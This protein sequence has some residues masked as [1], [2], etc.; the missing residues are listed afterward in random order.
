MRSR[1]L[2]PTY[3]I[4]VGVLHT[5]KDMAIEFGD[6]TGLLLGRDAIDRLNKI[7]KDLVSE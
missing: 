2:D 4:A 1:S 5:L 3:V 6:D 7:K